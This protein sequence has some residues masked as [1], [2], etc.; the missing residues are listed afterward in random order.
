MSNLTAKTAISRLFL[1]LT[2]TLLLFYSFTLVNASHCA[3]TDYDCQ[4]AEIQNEIDALSKAHE[5]NKN[6]L[7]SLKN[8]ITNLNSRIAGVSM[9]LKGLENDIRK[10][11]ED[12][13]FTQEVFEAKAANH[14]RFIRLYD[15]LLPF[16]SSEDASEAFREISFRQKAA[17]EDRKTM[18]LYA[19]ELIKLKEDKASLEKNQASLASAKTSLDAEA[20]FL[21]SEVDKTEAHLAQLSAKQQEILAAKAGSFTTS[22]GDIELA[23]DYNASIR[24]F[25]ESAPAGSFAVFSFGSYTHRRGMSQYGA[26]GRAANGQNHDAILRG[27]YNFDNYEDRGGVTI[28]VNNGGGVNSGNVVWTGS[29]EDYI[30]RIYEI[31]ASWPQ[32]SLE[33]QAIAAR[34]YVLSA[35]NNG[36]HSICATEKCQ[37]FKTTPKGGAW[38][39]AVNATSGK[40]MIS[41][42]QPL[43]AYYSST[44]GG[45]ILSKGWD[46][47]DG[48]GGGNFIDR[49]W[50]ARGGS[51]WLYKAWYRKGYTS[52]GDTCGRGNP[53]LTSAE[54]AD[55]VNA[56]LAMRK[57]G[58]DKDRITP[59]T[60]S[61]HSGNPYSFDELRNVAGGISS[62]ISI[63]TLQGNGTT[64]KV[65]INGTI[66]IGGIEFKEAFNAR[67]PGYL[68][69]P[70]GKGF[71]AFSGE[72]FAFFNIER[73]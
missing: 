54:L 51:P 38:E 66:E 3:T 41:G 48:Q 36:E 53:W 40:V 23:D 4:I 57:G 46:T 13:A 19:I 72:D 32:A 20:K 42:G 7:S 18:D 17:D 55:V 15:P 1:F 26:R 2:S 8:Q 56:A 68:R 45:F 12:L 34:S 59:I 69:I 50:E 43:K 21:G 58:V 10:R 33:A 44:T 28:K 47:T 37:V 35:T 9:Q 60:T 11:E 67:A 64:N 30:K 63:N 14:Y 52:S 62:V 6:Q 61:C 29:L 16:F 27:Y 65:V 31:P 39:D 24:G 73:K 70:Q 22:V 25:R 5:T 49:A 71:G